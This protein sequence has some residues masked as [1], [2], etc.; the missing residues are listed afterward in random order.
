MLN[1][2]CLIGARCGRR[3]ANMDSEPQHVIVTG[4]AGFLGSHLCRRLL[5]DGHRVLCVDNFLTGRQENI[6]DLLKNPRFE[7]LEHDIINPLP[8]TGRPTQIYNLACAA[9]PPRYQADPIHTLRT[10]VQGAY[11]VLELARTSG[12][13]ALQ[14][15]T[16]E[17]YGNPR[18]HP[19][20]ENYHGDVNPVGLR[21]CYDE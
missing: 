18:V 6:A 3:V 15:S 20:S 17:V 16:S 8:D 1:V 9:S 5:A 4:G 21:S 11:N 13:R 10:C 2:S 19:Q 7:L 14:A 12:A